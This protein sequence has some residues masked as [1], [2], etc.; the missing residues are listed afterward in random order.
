ML[1]FMTQTITRVRPEFITVNG[2]QVP[3]W[4][5]AAELAIP[6]WTVQPGEMDEELANRSNET[7]RYSA[8]GPAGA[9]IRANDGVMFE[10][11]LYQ[12]DGRPQRWP[13]PTGGLDH[14]FIR[15]VD[16]KG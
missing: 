15:L 4:E 8:L 5:N 1:S 14:T 16:H 7:A 2:R 3:D 13:S 12:V 9:D 6:G 10:G 11:E